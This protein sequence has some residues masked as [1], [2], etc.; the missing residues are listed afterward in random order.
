[1]SGLVFGAVV[2]AVSAAAV[3]I[4][5]VLI[6]LVWPA[7]RCPNCGAPL[8]RFRWPTSG[9]QLLWGGVTCSACGCQLNRKGN[10]LEKPSS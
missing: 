7:A 1:M 3:F 8:P 2:G 5:L 10:K 9:R 6:R 4:P